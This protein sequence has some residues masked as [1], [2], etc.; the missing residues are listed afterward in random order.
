M[1]WNGFQ[2]TSN[3]FKPVQHGEI[4]NVFILVV[5][6]MNFTMLY[7]VGWIAELHNMVK[8]STFSFWYSS[9]WISPC[10]TIGLDCRIAQDVEI[11]NVFILVLLQMNFTMLNNI[12][13]VRNSTEI[14]CFKNDPP[15]LTD[16]LTDWQSLF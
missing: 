7:N 16:W 4:A 11:V 1:L 13:H 15:W 8:L 12:F 6:Q 9:K 10:W 14:L 5:F 3:H 2:P